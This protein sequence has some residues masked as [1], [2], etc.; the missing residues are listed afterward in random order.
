ME[1]LVRSACQGHEQ[2]VAGDLMDPS[3][4]R[5]AESQGTVGDGLEGTPGVSRRRRDDPQH[6]GECPVC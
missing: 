6:L 1:S 4:T 3:A 5:S 2:N